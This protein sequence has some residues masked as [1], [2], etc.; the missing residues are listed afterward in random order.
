MILQTPPSA[1]PEVIDPRCLY[2]LR[3]VK[4]RLNWRHVALASA[5]RKG[6][7]VI[8]FGRQQYCRGTDV[9]ALFDRLADEQAARERSELGE[10]G[11][12]EGRGHD[13]R[14]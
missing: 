12:G 1:A 4:A 9:L 2:S 7:R 10:Q 13:A 5:K 8:K 11:T 3:E 6:L 14:D